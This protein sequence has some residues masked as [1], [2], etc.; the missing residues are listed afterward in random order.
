MLVPLEVLASTRTSKLDV[1]EEQNRVQNHTVEDKQF[2]GH[3]A[4]CHEN[5]FVF[6]LSWWVQQNVEL[7]I[8]GDAKVHDDLNTLENFG[9]EVSLFT[10]EAE[11]QQV[12]SDQ[13]GVH[14][15][16]DVQDLP[17]EFWLLMRSD[18]ARLGYW[19]LTVRVSED[20]E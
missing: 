4:F 20:D 13:E 12:R 15:S 2:H 14:T 6:A 7:L 9:D 3:P 17:S 8:E 1:G 18:W 16:D 11:S 19:S 10:A 5:E